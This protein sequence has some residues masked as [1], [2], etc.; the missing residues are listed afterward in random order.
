MGPS[1]WPWPAAPVDVDVKRRRC[2]GFE[3]AAWASWRRRCRRTFLFEPISDSCFLPPVIPARLFL[4]PASCV[5][6]QEPAYC[7]RLGLP[8]RCR[9]SKRLNETADCAGGHPASLCRS[10]CKRAQPASDR[11]CLGFLSQTPAGE[12][13]ICLPGSTYIVGRP[14]FRMAGGV[15]CSAAHRPTTASHCPLMLPSEG[16][17]VP[18]RI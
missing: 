13:Y 2:A 7:W 18:S 12:L 17:I 1:V 8:R 9:T 3:K 15:R 5:R 11:P 14:D 4:L 6:G 10:I 16:G